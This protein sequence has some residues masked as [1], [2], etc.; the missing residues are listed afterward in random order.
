VV[1]ARPDAVKLDANN[2]MAGKT[3]LSVKFTLDVLSLSM[4]NSS[5]GN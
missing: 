2:M 4:I 3:L 5:G 1:E